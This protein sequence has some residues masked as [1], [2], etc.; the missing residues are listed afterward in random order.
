MGESDRTAQ[1][2]LTEVFREEWPKLIGAA[3]RITG[4]LQSAE[5]VAQETLLAALDKWPLQGLPDRP[6][7]WLMTVCRNR[8]RNLVRDFG[9]ARQREESVLPLLADPVVPAPG[10][11][12]DDRLRLIALCC[13]P[14]LSADAQV[15]LTLRMVGGLTTEEIGHGFHVPGP[16]IAQ[17][18]VRARRTLREIGVDF[19]GDEPD[20]DERLPA[21]VD[22]IYLVFNEGYLASAGAGLTRGELAFEAYRLA[23][24]L[25][26]TAAGEPGP[27]ALRALLC[28]QLSRWSTRTGPDGSLLTLDQQDRSRW[29]LEL[30]G[31]GAQAL[32]RAHAWSEAAGGRDPLLVQAELAECHATADSFDATPWDKIVRLYDELLE[33]AD[34][35][36][37]AL[38]RAVAVA[39]ARGPAAALPLLDELSGD[40]ALSGSHRVWAVRA[41][42]HRRLGDPSAAAADYERALALVG[43]DTERRYL[44][45]QAKL[46]WKD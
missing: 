9:R 36:V 14:A 6:G 8:A 7:A 5:D 33:I 18:I 17:R 10:R 44:Q 32:G 22:V 42:L 23:V 13:H 28:F 30:I 39:M 20:L 4:D 26:E 45:K 37:V 3:A 19:A 2:A 40:P 31:E 16:T 27:Q 12:A 24:L 46:T 38:N 11:I 25:A 15:S 41:D 34:T 21:I 1:E 43:N 35:P 29:N